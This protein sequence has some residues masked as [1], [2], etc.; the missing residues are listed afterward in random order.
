MH[1]LNLSEPQDLHP[2]FRKQTHISQLDKTL[3]S[4]FRGI[5]PS[6][7]F[8]LEESMISLSYQTPIYIIYHT[9][10]WGSVLTR[11]WRQRSG[12]RGCWVCGVLWMPSFHKKK[13]IQII[14]EDTPGSTKIAGW[15]MDPDWRCIILFKN[16]RIFHLVTMLRNP[17]EGVQPRCYMA[18]QKGQDMTL[19]GTG[20]PMRQ[21]IFSEDLARLIVWVTCLGFVRKKDMLG[22]NL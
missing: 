14:Q 2:I 15:K 21:F 12:S 4:F 10:D 16:G 11:K 6:I 5:H 13:N 1:L 18:K 3:Y 7:H 22:F 8:L 9:L 19:W 20:T 17:T